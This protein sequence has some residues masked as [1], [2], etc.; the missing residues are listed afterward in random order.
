ML[1]LMLIETLANADEMMDLAG[2]ME[3]DAG[4]G[5]SRMMEVLIDQ[6]N[7]V[8]LE[9]I[10]AAIDGARRGDG[11]ETIAI[12]YGAGHLGEMERSLV[13]MGYRPTE[14]QWV[15]AIGVDPADTG[16]TRE[17][18]GGMRRMMSRMIES[19][20]DALRSMQQRD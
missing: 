2:G 17:Q 20:T 14:T 10:E 8:V 18:I 7:A 1:R 3:G 5:L 9:D 15:D 13:E 16:M 19:Q 11:P 4:A 6:R 12:F